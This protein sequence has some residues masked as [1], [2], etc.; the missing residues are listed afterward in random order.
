MVGAGVGAGI[1]AIPWLAA[2]T[3][4]LELVLVLVV[5]YGASCLVH[6]LLA[7]VCLRTGG[8]SRWSS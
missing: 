2:R 3:G 8:R 6:L 4:L 1:M 5:A 7:E